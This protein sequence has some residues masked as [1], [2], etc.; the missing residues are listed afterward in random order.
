M[1]RG[2]LAQ[3]VPGRVRALWLKV[4]SEPKLRPRRIVTNDGW[5]NDAYL[6]AG[7]SGWKW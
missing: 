5:G 7:H 3:V 1:L 4:E 6:F 2:R